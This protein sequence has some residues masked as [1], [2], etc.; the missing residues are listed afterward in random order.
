[1]QSR[2]KLF[3]YRKRK[4]GVGRSAVLIDLSRPE[5]EVFRHP[6]PYALVLAAAIAADDALAALRERRGAVACNVRAAAGL[7]ER[8]SAFRDVSSRIRDMIVDLI[9][10]TSGVRRKDTLTKQPVDFPS[11][12][13]E[14]AATAAGAAGFGARAGLSL[15]AGMLFSPR[16]GQSALMWPLPRQW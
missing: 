3:M 1:M 7:R 11:P 6:S 12:T 10:T 14:P 16:F 13:G 5:R 8:R 4:R 15:G 9:M 2:A